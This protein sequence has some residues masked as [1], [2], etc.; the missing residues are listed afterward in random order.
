MAYAVTRLPGK[1][2]VLVTLDVP[3]ENYTSNLRVICAYLTHLIAQAQEPLH[4]W[5]D[6]R[7]Q[8]ICF[9]DILIAADEV[10]HAPTPSSPMAQIAIIGSHP[11]LKVGVR[12]LERDYKLKMGQFDTLEA[13]FEHLRSTPRYPS[14]TTDLDHGPVYDR[15]I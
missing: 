6:L 7:N 8:E 12:R 4:I 13:A 11:L 9:C 3:L 5:F 10:A 14:K 15:E 1:P 2:V